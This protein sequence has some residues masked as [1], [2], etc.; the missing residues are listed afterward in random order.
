MPSR[1]QVRDVTDQGWVSRD[2]E[3]VQGMGVCGITLDEARVLVE[4][5]PALIDQ[6][7]RV[8]GDS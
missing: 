1:I 3:I 5:L 4:E 7:T 8:R 6:I 2:I